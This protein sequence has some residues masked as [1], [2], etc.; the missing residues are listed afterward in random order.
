MGSCAYRIR[1]KWPKKLCTPTLK[2]KVTDLFK[3]NAGAYDYWQAHRESDDLKT[4]KEFW[5]ELEKKFP[6]S[7]EFCKVTGLFGGPTEKLSGSFDLG[8]EENVGDL[9]GKTCTMDYD[10]G[11]VW[12][13]SDW[14]PLAKYL[15]SLGAT[16]VIWDSEEEQMELFSLYQYD[17]IVKAILEQADLPTLMGIHPD[18]DE[19]I[20]ERMAS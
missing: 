16:K 10:A 13:F 4:R 20:E 5:A 6:V 3:E 18:L 8:Q 12:H 15:K 2:K 11:N 9:F 14:R 19:L 1:A 7:A 17:E